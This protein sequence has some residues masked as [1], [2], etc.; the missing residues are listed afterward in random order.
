MSSFDDSLVPI[1]R[2]PKPR[3]LT[4]W[5]ISSAVM[6]ST[7]DANSAF[8]VWSGTIMNVVVILH[9]KSTT[10]TDWRP[11][12]S[13]N[14]CIFLS[15]LPEHATQLMPVTLN[16]N[17]MICVYAIGENVSS[18]GGNKATRSSSS[19]SL[20]LDDGENFSKEKLFRFII[21]YHCFKFKWILHLVIY[22]APQ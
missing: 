5:L 6:S 1:D 16:S 4:A 3:A 21:M 10:L 15:M 17:S 7:S 11:R 19:P 20:S 12:V 18:M 8:F 14:S 22:I 9:V 13:N 2:Q